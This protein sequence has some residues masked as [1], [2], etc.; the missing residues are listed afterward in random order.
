MVNLFGI[1]LGEFSLTIEKID[2][3][4]YWVSSEFIVIDSLMRVYGN[5]KLELGKLV[6]K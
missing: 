3:S 2:D 6:C 4:L 1:E 5:L